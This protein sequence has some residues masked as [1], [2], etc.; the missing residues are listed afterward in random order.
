MSTR[1][2]VHTRM[3]D[4]VC[5]FHSQGSCHLLQVVRAFGVQ[6]GTAL[7]Q[8]QRLLDLPFQAHDQSYTHTFEVEHQCAV[9]FTSS[10]HR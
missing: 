5:V 6:D 7:E 9:Y 1:V 3:H 8:L 4:R 10:P 2:H